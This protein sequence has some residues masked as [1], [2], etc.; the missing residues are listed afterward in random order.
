MKIRP[1]LTD[2]IRAVLINPFSYDL[3]SGVRV[4]KALLSAFLP[5]SDLQF[6]R[7]NR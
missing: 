5:L 6:A 2:K 4:K 1:Y 7:V 3:N